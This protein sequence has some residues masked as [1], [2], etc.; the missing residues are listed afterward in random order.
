MESLAES[1]TQHSHRF[2]HAVC[3]RSEHVTLCECQF[4]YMCISSG[5]IKGPIT[6][7]Q[8]RHSANQNHA[9]M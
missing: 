8:L 6:G 1:K 7:I 4:P 5:F 9:L 2:Y 3:V